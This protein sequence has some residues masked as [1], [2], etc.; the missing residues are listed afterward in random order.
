[1][2]LEPL[3]AQHAPEMFAVLADP[4]IYE[5]E[6][7][8]PAS[9][10]ALTARY[11]RLGSRQSPDGKQRWLNWVIR[12]DTGEAAGYVQATVTQSGAAYVAYELASRFW[13]RGIGSAAV[14]AMI[15]K[16]RAE[17]GVELFFAVLK[18]RNYR[19]EGLLRKIGFGAASEEEGEEFGR[20][21]DEMV[22]VMR[23]RQRPPPARG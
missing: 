10:E 8:P 6:N 9:L 23:G 2:K 21:A 12:L 16:L 13:R 17:H 11:R 22:M 7:E 15:D 3:T 18:A 20:E 19:S 1:M 14:R 4:A 5:F